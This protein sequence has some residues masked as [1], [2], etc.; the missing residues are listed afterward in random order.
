MSAQPSNTSSKL[1]HATVDGSGK[2]P[3]AQGFQGSGDNGSSGMGGSS[4]PTIGA[5]SSL[6]DG[7]AQEVAGTLSQDFTLK[8]MKAEY[9][10]E[11]KVVDN[12]NKE[13]GPTYGTGGDKVH[14]GLQ[15]HEVDIPDTYDASRPREN[16]GGNQTWGG[17]LNP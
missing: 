14:K 10:G 13:D 16:I 12:T 5:N 3:G 8:G 15:S 6:R 2:Q 4:N 17:R 9:K 7:P 1:G 11:D